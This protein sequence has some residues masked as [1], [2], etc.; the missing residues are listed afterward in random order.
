[1]TID[2]FNLWLVEVFIPAVEERRASLRRQ[3]GTFNEKAVLIMD[4][5]KCHKIEPFRQ[6]LA[7]KNITV[8]FLVAHSSHLTHPLDLGGFGRLKS[9]TR[10]EASYVM[11]LEEL[12]EAVP[13][14]DNEPEPVR[15]ERGKVLADF[16]LAILDAYERA[17]TRKWAVSAGP[18]EFR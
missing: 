9:L 11:R 12:D 5:C 17:A 13:D 10:D 16:V 15:A 7:E 18:S 1:M 14:E 4:G 3:L 2:V 8:V 6:M